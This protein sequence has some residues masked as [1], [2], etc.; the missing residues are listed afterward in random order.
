MKILALDTATKT[1]SVALTDDGSLAAESTIIKNQTHTKH[2]MRLIHSVLEISGFGLSDMDGFAVTIGPGSFTGLR[3]GI[4]TIKGLAQALGKPVVGIS[5]L[6]ALA[7]Q[8]ADPYHFARVR[9]TGQPT[10]STVPALSK[11][12][13]HGQQPLKQFLKV[14]RSPVYLSEMVLSFI[15]N[16]LQPSWEILLILSLKTG[17]S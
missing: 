11:K 4:S 10:V 2:L 13:Q 14:S 8:G 15:T 1:C 7:W 17:K 6:K 9:Y 12:R 16:K 3:I 5:S